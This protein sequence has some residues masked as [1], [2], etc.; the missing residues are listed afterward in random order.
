MPRTAIT[1]TRLAAATEVPA[2]S[3]NVDPTNGHVISLPTSDAL[4]QS[5]GK[6]QLLIL[7]LVNT[8]AGSKTVTIKAAAAP[9]AGSDFYAPFHD[10]SAK[11]DLAIVMASQNDVSYV[12][13]LDSSR[14]AQADGTLWVDYA[15]AMTGTIEAYALPD[16]LP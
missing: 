7:R 3:Q 16:P 12:A 6:T 11:G 4:G 9:T 1:A 8:F 2:V 15:A 13:G 10:Q 5:K 14:F